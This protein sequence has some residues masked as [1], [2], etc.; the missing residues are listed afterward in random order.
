MAAPLDQLIAGDAPEAAVPILTVGSVQG[1]WAA[2][3]EM[4]NSIA[5]RV[6]KG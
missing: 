1:D 2:L 3:G 4:G 5:A 6:E